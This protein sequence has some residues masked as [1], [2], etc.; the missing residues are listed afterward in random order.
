MS[1]INVDFSQ[2]LYNKGEKGEY[3]TY[4]FDDEGKPS[5]KD[6]QVLTL[7]LAAIE[8]LNYVGKE[9]KNTP[10]ETVK[11]GRLSTRI[12]LC[13]SPLNLSHKNCEV[14]KSK[15]SKVYGPDITFQ[16][17]NLLDGKEDQF[18]LSIED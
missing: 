2:V 7:K 4:S 5:V 18:D 3:L 1:Q 11:F 16:A 14:L 15:I 12:R 13:D 10:E 17:A 8:A 6:R 9:D